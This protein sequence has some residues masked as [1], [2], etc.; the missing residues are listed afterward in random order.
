MK[1][2]KTIDYLHPFIENSAD[3]IVETYVEASQLALKYLE[4]PA[5]LESKDINFLESRR[6]EYL[7]KYFKLDTLE[8]TIVRK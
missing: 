4:D 7:E 1:D 8:E 2:G 3:K 6:Q 5:T